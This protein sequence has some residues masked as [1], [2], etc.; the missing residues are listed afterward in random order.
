MDATNFMYR[1]AIE[2]IKQAELLLPFF[3]GGVFDPL[4]MLRAYVIGS[5]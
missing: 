1:L 5:R 4:Y 3:A 2:I